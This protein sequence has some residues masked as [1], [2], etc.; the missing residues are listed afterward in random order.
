MRLNV[1]GI[2]MA[3]ALAQLALSATAVAGVPLLTVDQKEAQTQAITLSGDAGVKTASAA[4]IES[5][6]AA[7]PGQLADGKTNLNAAV[8]ELVFG[9]LLALNNDPAHPK[10]LWSQ[11]LPYTIGAYQVAGGRYGGDDPDRIYRSIAADPNHQYVI[12]GHRAAGASLDFSFE[13]ISGPAL[14]GKAKAALQAK[15]IDVGADGSFTVTADATPV[16]GRRNHLQLPPGT[17][18]ILA[19]DTLN[20]WASQLPNELSV[21]RVDNVSADTAARESVAQRA[22]LE[23]KKSID[24]SLSFLAGVWKNPPNHLFPVVRGLSDGV[25]GGIVAVNR[26]HLRNDEALVITLDPLQARYVGVEVTD[27]WLRSADYARRSTS[28]NDKQAELSRDG[29]ITYVLSAK[30]PGS[31]NWLDSAG[32]Q[33]G[34]LLVRWEV[35]P[36]EVQATRAVRSVHVVK[37]AG[38]TGSLP[39]GASPVD[40]SQRQHLLEAR[41]TSYER[42]LAQD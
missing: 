37:L 40:A 38:L 32:L 41:R 26:F 10:V 7:P 8:D 20:D 14:W 19:R 3:A 31:H 28:L 36:G 21:E 18:N 1:A 27:P 6:R 12:H 34:I 5:Y 9:T 13:A 35:L 16:D 2:A 17:A 15:D 29:T 4:A 30:D 42:R 24:E 25:K 22:P 39:A 11:S 33:D 23:V